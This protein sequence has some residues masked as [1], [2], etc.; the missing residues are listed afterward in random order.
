LDKRRVK[1]NSE[2][3][4]LVRRII[5]R[6]PLAEE[7]W[8]RR[9]S[10]GVFQIIY[11][12]VHNYSLAEDLRQDTLLKA[13]EKIRNGELREPERLSG[14]VCSIAKFI[15][16]EHVRKMRAAVKVEDVAAADRL[17]DSAPDPYELVLQKEKAESVRKLISEM[18]VER[19]RDIL[20]RYYILEEERDAICAALKISREQFNGIIFRAHKRYKELHRKHAGKIK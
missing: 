19:D 8:V 1:D 16:L 17:P 12:V 10:G 3:G 5:G 18:K 15:A 20:F 4:D 14:Y 6:D 11:Q 9:Y 2:L 7:E 13:L